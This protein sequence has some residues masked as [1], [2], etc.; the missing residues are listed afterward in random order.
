MSDHYA[1]SRFSDVHAEAA[2]LVA[3]HGF[4]EKITAPDGAYV[5]A[6]ITPTALL[7]LDVVLNLDEAKLRE[8]YIKARAEA[9]G[10]P[11]DDTRIHDDFYVIT[12]ESPQGFVH[13]ISSTTNIE[14]AES[15][16]NYLLVD[17]NGVI[18]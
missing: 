17:T 3:N 8:R 13:T 10:C 15:D 5:F 7:N 1:K 16:W 18:A 9:L 2:T 6:T 14:Q 12:W 4:A 11:L